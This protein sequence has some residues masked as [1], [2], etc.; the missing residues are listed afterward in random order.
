MTGLRVIEQDVRAKCI[1]LHFVENASSSFRVP[2]V[3]TIIS[4]AKKH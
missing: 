4:R 2:C 3:E 1:C